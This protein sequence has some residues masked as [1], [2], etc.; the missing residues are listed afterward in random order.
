MTQLNDLPAT[1]LMQAGETFA[2]LSDYEW[3]E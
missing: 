1:E 3:S 2:R